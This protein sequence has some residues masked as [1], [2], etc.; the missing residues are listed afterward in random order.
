MVLMH[1]EKKTIWVNVQVFRC[2][3]GWTK[4]SFITD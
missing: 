3:D 4:S 1:K 2:F